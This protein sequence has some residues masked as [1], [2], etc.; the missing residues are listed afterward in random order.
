MI[1]VENKFKG[2]GNKGVGVVVVEPSMEP[3]TFFV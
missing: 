3:I 2:T 1:I